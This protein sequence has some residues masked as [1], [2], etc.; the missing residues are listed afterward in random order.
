MAIHIDNSLFLLLLL[1]FI[2]FIPQ[3]QL[4]FIFLVMDMVEW[5]DKL[6][7]KI[8]NLLFS[9]YDIIM[10]IINNPIILTGLIIYLCMSIA[11]FTTI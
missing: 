11:R 5:F 10:Y 2:A 4:L 8:F 6:Y 1:F 7:Q 9:I 3:I